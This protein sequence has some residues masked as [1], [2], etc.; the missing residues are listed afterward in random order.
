MLL[1]P[2]QAQLSQGFYLSAKVLGESHSTTV[3][4]LSGFVGSSEVWDAH[5]QGLAN[6]YRLIMLDTLGFGRSP[7][8][9]IEY[10]LAQHLEAIDHTLEHYGAE[11][12][13]IVGHSMGCLLA[14]A[15]AN[16]YPAKAGRLALLA[17]PAFDDEQQARRSIGTASLFNRWLAMDTPVARW[18]CA[19]MC[20]LRPAL[21]PLAPHL[22]RHVPA[23]VA[24]DA[25]RHN[26]QSYSRTLRNVIFQAE[27]HRWMLQIGGPILFIHGTQ[28]KTAPYANVQ[29]YVHLPNVRV[30]TLEADHGLI[31][32]HGRLIASELAE[33]FA[34][35]G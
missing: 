26:W 6:Q 35:R 4:F 8:P 34:T 31:F 24:K 1:S 12:V 28:D 13:H 5:F 18:A 19:L 22:V 27:T 32:T 29:R 17:C 30:L 7:K 33:F 15:Y 21:L 14:L 25:L 3:L 2:G 23:V 20:T 16:R 11:R 9:D 10:S